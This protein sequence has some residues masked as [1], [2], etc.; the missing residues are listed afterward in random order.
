MQNRQDELYAKYMAFH[1]VMLE[2]YTAIEIA[3][4]LTIQGLSF[5]KTILSEEDYEKIVDNISNMRGRV[6][7]FDGPEIL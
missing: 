7:T 3:A 6:N 2:E 4:V 5:Y 1:S